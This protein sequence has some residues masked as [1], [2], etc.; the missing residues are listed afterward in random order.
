MSW[1]SCL[2]KAD[3]SWRL[4]A[5]PTQRRVDY[6]SAGD[7]LEGGHFR[8]EQHFWNDYAQELSRVAL[9]FTKNRNV[10][11]SARDVS[12]RVRFDHTAKPGE[13][14]RALDDEC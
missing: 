4:S 8:P 14:S 2:F 9:V 12:C 5:R 6:W 7:A 3:R 1:S 10:L 13:R 11:P